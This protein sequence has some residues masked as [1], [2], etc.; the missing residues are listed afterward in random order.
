MPTMSNFNRNQSY[1]YSQSSYKDLPNPAVRKSRL[2]KFLLDRSPFTTFLLIV[3]FGFVF[4]LLLSLLLI[5]TYYGYY[6]L[7]GRILP[8][9]MV[10]NTNLGGLTVQEAAIELQKR[11]NLDNTILITNGQESIGLLPADL[12]LGIDALKTAVRAHEVGHGDMMP[13]EFM[14]MIVS[15]NE[16]WSINP[17]IYF[18]KEIASTS[19]TAITPQLSLAPT[20]ASLIVEG[21]NVIPV[22]GKYGYSVNLDAT[23]E[24]L[25][26]DP[27]S[28]LS[29][30]AFKVT[31]MPVI[32]EVM[33][34]SAAAS[35]AQALVANPISLIAYDA[36]YDEYYQ[37][38]IEGNTLATW[39]SVEADGNSPRATFD[40]SKVATYLTSLNGKLGN[41][42]FID[43]DRYNDIVVESILRTKEPFV[44]I[45]HL[46]TTYIVQ[47]GDTLLK[48]GWKLGIP[49]WMILQANPDIN[50]DTLLIGTELV[51]PSKDDLLPLPIVAHKRIV[52][53]IG[54]QHM[55]IYEN[56]ERINNYKISTGI[57]RSPTQPGIFQ[58][59]THQKNAYASVW[60]LHMP[61]FLGIYEA[62]PGFFNGIH[63]LPTLSSGRRLW[64]NILGRPASYG[65]IILDTEPAKWLYNWAED[66]VVVE[67]I[68]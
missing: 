17:I 68:Q 18:D 38:T 65:C 7:S 8:G 60:D 6:Q 25:E 52:I 46:P 32:P 64:A 59:Q 62:W 20:N 47:K 53:S 11:W 10:G 45:S 12:G 26:T 29:T 44:P 56:G 66:G 24:F 42:Q 37:W 30:G 23:M 5:I 13:V 3:S 54:K 9:V 31:L 34:A 48:I 58:V 1:E 50:P 63:G 49:Y 39:L 36:I 67:I 14:Q 27:Q 21:G 22:P 35:E 41:Q 2:P 43:G 19:L 40:E 55:W 33:D 61:N 57:D 51:V 28:V 16:G 15:L 4:A